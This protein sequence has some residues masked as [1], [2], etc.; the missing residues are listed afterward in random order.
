MNDLRVE[1][2]GQILR[3]EGRDVIAPFTLSGKLRSD[4]VVEL[5]KQYKDR[6]HV[7]YVGT[8]DGEGTFHGRWDIGGYQGEWTIRLIGSPDQHDSEI[9]DVG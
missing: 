2:L 9:Q 5:I 4:G 1:F 6:H 8:Y 7:L 3:G